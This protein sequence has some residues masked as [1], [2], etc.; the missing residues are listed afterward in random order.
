MISFTSVVV[1]VST[2]D[3]SKVVVTVGDS[4]ETLVVAT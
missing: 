2:N 3:D 1:R 4:L